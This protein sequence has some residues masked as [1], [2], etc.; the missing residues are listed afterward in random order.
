M[1]NIENEDW[2]RF[3]RQGY[4]RLGRLLSRRD[5]EELRQR[6]VA[7]MLGKSG[8]DTSRMLMQLD[9]ETG[10]Y[11]DAPPQTL[12]FKGSTL[13]Y[14]KIQD[15]ERDPAYL[16]FMQHPVFRAACARAYGPATPV[17]AYRAMFMNKPAG[18]GTVLPWHQD[19][20]SQ[21]DRDPLLTA[22]TALDPSTTRNGCVWIIPGSHKYGVINPDHGSGFLTPEQA[23]HHCPPQ[24]AIPLEVEAGETVLLHNWLLHSSGVNSSMQS[25]RAFSVCYM[26]AATVQRDTRRLASR[27]VIFGAGA[28]SAPDAAPHT[29]VMAATTA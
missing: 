15:L 10:S 4:L 1:N 13:N 8:L 14:R 18:K 25:R 27:S 20:W 24:N 19:R 12:G 21:L 5:E 6:I 7:I 29:Q 22:W 17:A 28:L 26:E 23:E 9:S 16:R 2:D 3:M 11:A